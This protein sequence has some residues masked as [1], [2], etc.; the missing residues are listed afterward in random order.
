MYLLPGYLGLLASTAEYSKVNDVLGGGLILGYPGVGM[1][2]VIILIE[3]VKKREEEA[4]P[5]YHY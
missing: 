3:L 2:Y 4:T 5:L 1:F